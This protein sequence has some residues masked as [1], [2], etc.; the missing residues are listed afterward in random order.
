MATGLVCEKCGHD[1]SYVVDCRPS[2]DGI[3]RRRECE[4]CGHRWTTYE[5]DRNM[6]LRLR[7]LGVKIGV[8]EGAKAQN[9]SGNTQ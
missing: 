1:K 9:A 5:F 7:N 3:R 4:N 8:R 2:A 6:F